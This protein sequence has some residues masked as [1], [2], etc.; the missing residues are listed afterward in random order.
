MD[1]IVDRI[2]DAL[3][4]LEMMANPRYPTDK[5]NTIQGAHPIHGGTSHS[6]KESSNFTVDKKKE[7]WRCWAHDT[8]G[9]I[10]TFIA[11]EEGLITCN[12]ANNIGDIFPEVLEVAADRA[13]VELNLDAKDRKQLKEEK[14]EREAIYEVHQAAHDY[15]RQNLTGEVREWI[16]EKYGFDDEI[17]DEFEIGYAPPDEKGL[18]KYLEKNSNEYAYSCGLLLKRGNDWVDFF[19]GRVVFPYF[20]RDEVVYFIARK[21]PWTASDEDWN[22]AKY[23]K[24]QVGDTKEHV[25]DQVENHLYGLDSIRGEDEIIV[26]EGVTDAISVQ[27]MDFPCLSPVTVRFKEDDIHKVKKRLRGKKAI[28]IN[29]GDEAGFEGGLDTLKKI[30]NSAMVKLPDGMDLNDWYREKGEKEA[31]RQLLDEA[32]ERDEALALYEDDYRYLF[33]PALNEIGQQPSR[34][35]AQ[36]DNQAQEYHYRG[37][38]DILE[39]VNDLKQ[40]LAIFRRTES[41]HPRAP[42]G[43]EQRQRK[44][45]ISG[46][47]RRCLQKE[48]KFLYDPEKHQVFYFHGKSHQVFDISSEEFTSYL[49]ELFGIS[50]ETKEGKFALNEIKETGISKGDEVRVQKLWYFDTDDEV[51]YIHN[52]KNYYY[53]LDGNS[54]T[55]EPNGDEIY[56]ETQSDVRPIKYLEEDERDYP[57]E[58]LGQI[59]KWKGKGDVIAQALANRTNFVGKTALSDDEQRLQHLLNIYVFPFGSRLNA[60]PITCFIGQK[61]SGKSATMKMLGRFLI[62]PHFN[63][64][65]LPNEQDFLVTAMNNPMYFLDNVDTK[66]EWVNDALASIATGVSIKKRELYTDFGQ[67]EA[68]IDTFLGLNARTPKFRRDDVVDRL[69]IFYVERFDNFLDEELLYQPLDKHYNTL[70]SKYMDNLNDVVAEYQNTDITDMSSSH[71]LVEW[72]ILAKIISRGLGIDQKKVSDMIES[73]R[74]ERSAFS[75]QNDSILNAVRRFCE[76]HVD[77]QR[78]YSAGELYDELCDVS[79]EFEDDYETSKSLSMR[80]PNVQSELSDLVGLQQRYN[81][82][83][84][85]NEYNFKGGNTIDNNGYEQENKP[86]KGVKEDNLRD[87]FLDFVMPP[88]ESINAGDRLTAL[89]DYWE[90]NVDKE[91]PRFIAE[92]VDEFSVDEVKE[93]WDYILGRVD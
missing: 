56:F 24:Q 6:D 68:K 30:E 72:V 53:K 40:S 37:L 47:V 84:G 33:L 35:R 78:W 54:I 43:I 59:D 80:L 25:S 10:L 17:I 51:L 89:R 41:S 66:R 49:Y 13:G 44:R 23:L 12:E 71:R 92:M 93:V 16:T 28:V 60:K 29:D 3:P 22:K 58:I 19:Q 27:A 39:G 81:K 57:D 4:P 14:Q 32:L 26:T 42:T 91:E 70:W 82:K 36:W 7:I 77:H 65:S 45:V 18:R 11:M 88:D 15:F 9:D 1:E 62:K 67:A 63:L 69:L 79:E 75:L 74:Y 34:V 20:R 46:V 8:W 76:H 83:K 48:G 55:K 61:G 5:G 31:F 52:H 50:R 90:E 2:K 85:R 73:M 64:A 87:E 38:F 21:T 86:W